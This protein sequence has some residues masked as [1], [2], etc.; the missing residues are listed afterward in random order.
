VKRGKTTVLLAAYNKLTVLEFSDA[1]T[2]H[3]NARKSGNSIG[4]IP[5][6]GP[7]MTPEVKVENLTFDKKGP[8]DPTQPIT[9]KVTLRALRRAIPGQYAL[10]MQM[11]GSAVG[12]RFDKPVGADSETFTFQF[13]PIGQRLQGNVGATIPLIFVVA[14]EAAVRTAQG[15]ACLISEPMISLVDIAGR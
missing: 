12:Y 14:R 9:G 5:S 8:I 4:D 2:Q 10:L 11:Q 15:D 3:D 1:Q 7:L 6:G 13:D